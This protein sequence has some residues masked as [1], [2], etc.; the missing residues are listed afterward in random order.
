MHDTEGGTTF[1]AGCGKAL[2]VRDWYEI[3]EY[4]LS[5]RGRCPDCGRALAGRFGT[6]EQAFGAR[7]IPIAIHRSPV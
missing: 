5:P 3:L 7:R 4:R 2:I 1:C 6:C